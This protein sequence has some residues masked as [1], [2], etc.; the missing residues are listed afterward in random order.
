M[1]RMDLL[2]CSAN[3]LTVLVVA[4]SGHQPHRLSP[5]LLVSFEVEK[6]PNIRLSTQV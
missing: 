6:R 2:G 5:M 4:R 3:L 1:L